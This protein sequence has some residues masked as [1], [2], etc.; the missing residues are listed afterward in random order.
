MPNNNTL[1]GARDRVGMRGSGGGVGVG[2]GTGGLDPTGKLHVIWVDLDL[3]PLPA[4]DEI[5]WIRAWW[6]TIYFTGMH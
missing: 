2:E 6:G 3:N 1:C 5:S 4:L